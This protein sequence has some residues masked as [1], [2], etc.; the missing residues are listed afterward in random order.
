MRVKLYILQRAGSA[1][2]KFYD[3][4]TAPSPRRARIFIAEKGLDIATVNID[5]GAGE[6]FSDEFTQINPRCTVPVLE[7]DDG[8]RITE[9]AGIAAYLDAAY[10]DP[11]LLGTTPVERALVANWNARV[12]Q[13]G[14]WAVAEAFRNQ[15]KGLKNRA[16]TGPK[17]FVQIPDLVER[18]RARAAEFFETLDRRLG[19]APFLAGAQFSVADIT[20]LCVVD[21][22]AWIK[23]SIGKDQPNLRRW[24]KEIGARTSAAL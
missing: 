17:Q 8:T 3:C 16:L 15:T 9:N 12:E 18:G 5:L 11:P 7:L 14:L 23:L 4:R 24:H 2:V 21:F 13:E 10:P 1:T 20:A 22:A 6:Q 19:D